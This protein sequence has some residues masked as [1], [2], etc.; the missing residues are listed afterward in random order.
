[1]AKILKCDI[2]KRT[3]V[4]IHKFKVKKEVYDWYEKSWVRLDVC[5]QCLSFLRT[6][7]EK[8]EKPLNAMEIIMARIDDPFRR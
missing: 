6:G 2:C 4:E 7:I 5:E 8:K 3:D 1:M